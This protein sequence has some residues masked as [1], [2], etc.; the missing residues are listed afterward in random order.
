V[1]ADA[2]VTPPPPAQRRPPFVVDLISFCFVLLPVIAGLWM[3]RHG[4]GYTIDEWGAWAVVIALAL[5]VSLVALPVRLKPL[6]YLPAGCLFGLAGLAF[7]SMEWA[8]LPQDALV[9]GDRFFFAGCVLGLAT[10]TLTRAPLR[11]AA[12]G[13]VVAGSAG[14]AFATGFGLLHGSITAGSFELGR[15]V[16]AIGYGGG[17]AAVMAIGVWPLVAFA[18]DRATS[19]AWR[20]LAGAGGAAAFAAVIPTGARAALGALVIAGIVFLVVSPTPLRSGVVALPAVLGTA[21]EW[22]SLNLAY[23]A[24]TGMSELHTVGRSI[25]LIALAGGLVALT[26]GL[27]DTRVQLTGTA[28][29]ALLLGSVVVLMAFGGIVF[30]TVWSTVNGHPVGWVQSEWHSFKQQGNP[31]RTTS[32]TRFTSV[33]GGRYDLWRAALRVFFVHPLN[34][35][36]A[37][38][39][40]YVYLQEGRSA[41]QPQQA[42]SEPLEV[43]ATLGYPGVLLLIPVMALPI[44]VAVRNRLASRLRS[45][46]LMM[47]GLAAALTEFVCHSSIDWTWHIAA[48]SIPALLLAGAVMS[49]LAAGP[50]TETSKL[51]AGASALW[52]HWARLLAPAVAAVALVG[53]AIGLVVP[54]TLA[55][56][57]LLSSYGM[58]PL[59]AIADAH[60]A[61]RW[62]WLSSR[63]D[64][65]IARAD[66]ASGD[67][68][69]ALQAAR[70]AVRKEPNFWVA[71]QM[72]YLASSRGTSSA[73]LERAYAMVRRLNPSL[74]LDFRY[75]VPPP[76]Y[77]HY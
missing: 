18:S 37:G 56:G 17:T 44:G 58:P 69:G 32:A 11:R 60:K 33:G 39:F 10:V 29:Q 62:D 16:G 7:L 9:D 23:S 57:Y 25:L 19:L 43:A 28:R 49:S 48:D 55:Q 41:A 71:W 21:V 15:L 53:V 22:H 77:D 3:A 59:V 63:P 24:G 6:A 50:R 76:T 12:V 75:D 67:Y 46:R 1:G 68:S 14:V 38:N 2:P 74:P 70:A 66:L 42:H 64:I 72:L 35:V 4:G 54:P 52:S 61:A 27:V 36:G 13:V 26:Q 34:G 20:P 31:Y 5:A 40:A 30:G 45:E 51:K 65:A 73:D 47:A 8:A